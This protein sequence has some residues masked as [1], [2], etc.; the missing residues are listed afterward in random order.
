MYCSS[1][2]LGFRDIFID[3]SVNLELTN[4]ICHLMVAFKNFIVSRSF[5]DFNEFAKMLMLCDAV[6]N[7]KCAYVMYRWRQFGLIVFMTILAEGWTPFY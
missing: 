6:V 7:G 2:W 5:D 1:V 4:S 3:E